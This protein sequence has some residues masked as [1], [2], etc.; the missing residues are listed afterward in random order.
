LTEYAQ[1]DLP[2]ALRRKEAGLACVAGPNQGWIEVART[3]AQEIAVRKGWVTADCVRAVLYPRNIRP[4]HHN[5][6]G[7]VFRSGFRFTGRFRK[8]RVVVGHG[9]LQRV[10]ELN[11]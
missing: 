9:N 8:S 1:M 10:W 7:V 11:V 6:W 3:V 4:C 5:A 2:E